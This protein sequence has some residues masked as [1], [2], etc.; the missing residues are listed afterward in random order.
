MYSKPLLESSSG[1]GRNFFVSY[2]FIIVSYI[3]VR[4]VSRLTDSYSAKKCDGFLRHFH[5]SEML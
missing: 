5:E 1:A 2:S 4:E 3:A